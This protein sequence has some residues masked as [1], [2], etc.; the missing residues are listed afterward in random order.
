MCNNQSAPEKKEQA[1]TN[2]ALIGTA[3]ENNVER[4]Y[5]CLSIHSST[6]GVL[7]DGAICAAVKRGRKGRY[8]LYRTYMQYL[9]M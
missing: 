7:T 8:L 6:S 9:Q 1:I 4:T 3:A 2:V 5:V